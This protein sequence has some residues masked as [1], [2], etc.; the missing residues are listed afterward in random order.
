MAPTLVKLIC[1]WTKEQPQCIPPMCLLTAWQFISQYRINYYFWMTL[2]VN[3]YPPQKKISYF[4]I[5][6]LKNVIPHFF[7]ANNWIVTPLIKKF[8]WVCVFLHLF[9]CV[10]EDNS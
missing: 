10:V 8:F 2:R 5:M 4:T 9:F 7:V 6:F 3:P 1:Q